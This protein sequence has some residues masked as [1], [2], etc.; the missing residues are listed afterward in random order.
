MVVDT[1]SCQI[2]DDGGQSSGNEMAQGFVETVV[3]F[4]GES[5]LEN[6]I[7]DGYSLEVEG[8]GVAPDTRVSDDLVYLGLVEDIVNHEEAI[9]S[10]LLQD[11]NADEE[12]FD[13]LSEV[14][15]EYRTGSERLELRA[16]DSRLEHTRTFESY[17]NG[18]GMTGEEAARY[19]ATAHDSGT[20]KRDN[21][22]FQ[23]GHGK[24]SLAVIGS[25]DVV[26][27][28][29][30]PMNSDKLYAVVITVDDKDTKVVRDEDGNIPSISLDSAVEMYGEEFFE[31]SGTMVRMVNYDMLS[32]DKCPSQVTGNGFMRKLGERIARVHNLRLIDMIDESEEEFVG[33]YNTAR[34]SMNAFSDHEILDLFDGSDV[35]DIEAE[36][37][38]QEPA[39]VRDE[40]FEDGVL[41]RCHAGHKSKNK[42][43][44]MKDLL[45]TQ[46]PPV[47][48]IC[49]SSVHET[50]S[51]SWLDG[52]FDNIDGQVLV[53][54]K[55][56]GNDQLFDSRRD[57]LTADKM[58]TRIKRRLE[59]KLRK[60]KTLR[61]ADNKREDYI[62]KKVDKSDD[63]DE[64]S[65]VSVDEI[66]EYSYNEL[67][68]LDGKAGRKMERVVKYWYNKPYFKLGEAAENGIH[69]AEIALRIVAEYGFGEKFEMVHT[70]ND[71]SGS[72]GDIAILNEESGEVVEVI[73]MKISEYGG[74]GTRF[75]V[76]TDLLHVAGV[77]GRRAPENCT[78]IREGYD[79]NIEEELRKYHYPSRLSSSESAKSV[80]KDRARYLRDEV[81][82]GYDEEHVVENPSE[83]EEYV[84]E[85]A[86]I[87]NIV[88]FYGQRVIKNCIRELTDE[89]FEVDNDR[90]R[91]L[92]AFLT[93]G[94]HTERHIQDAMAEFRKGED[95]TDIIN[96]NYSVAKVHIDDGE[97]SFE[98]ENTM[99]LV[100]TILDSEVVLKPPSEKENGEMC[101]YL[102]IGCKSASEEYL[103]LF[104]LQ[105]N[106][107]N[108]FQGVSSFS[109][110]GME[111]KFF[112]NEE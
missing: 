80:R 13:S 18:I 37:F 83:Y 2:L 6:V 41:D 55:C 50:L 68:D 91:A 54:V 74:D 35:L 34:N 48:F 29:T 12:A 65:E 30:T 93:A 69:G 67:K 86:R 102:E 98:K 43:T 97:V 33:S 60:S 88:E 72:V 51:H 20:N 22:L 82:D 87:K 85:A 27:V 14:F 89:A 16:F 56:S 79:E 10:R 39:T 38:V 28:L 52:V 59:R 92:A 96:S 40:L 64:D 70:G 21:D 99:S 44:K 103:S 112:D 73:E 19:L 110:E 11:N 49:K 57:S 71:Y 7:P 8:R 100:D 109:I 76:T 84:V 77:F 108:V 94:I 90:L 15:D 101:K 66:A 53:F 3:E 9:G 5:D 81:L 31:D 75:N 107:R 46:S 36:V 23:G 58:T 42:G 63:S 106:W 32:E 4:Y 1:D 61:Q 17:D 24:G 47:R 105:F 104:R 95:V 26:V 78:D 45:S 111:G 25:S 62:D